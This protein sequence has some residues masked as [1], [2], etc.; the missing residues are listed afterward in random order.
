MHHAVCTMPTKSGDPSRGV[1]L[2]FRA[3]RL[4]SKPI[5][6]PIELD[7]DFW[8]AKRWSRLTVIRNRIMPAQHQAGIPT[9]I[10]RI[11]WARE[12]APRQANEAT[13][14]KNHHQAKPGDQDAAIH[15]GPENSAG[16]VGWGWGAR[17]HVRVVVPS[18][19]FLPQTKHSR[20]RGM[21]MR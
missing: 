10:D 1:A 18:R 4:R 17:V 19:R 12:G 20:L 11:E 3:G 6:H 5:N 15:E 7:P 9:I 8:P 13:H 14:A 16:R 2:K 21:R